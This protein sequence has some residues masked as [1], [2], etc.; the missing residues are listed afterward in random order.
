MRICKEGHLGQSK[1][2]GICGPEKENVGTFGKLV[3]TGG[4]I[5]P[6]GRDRLTVHELRSWHRARGNARGRK[7]AAV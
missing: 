4:M 5:H 7:S 3:D 2:C 1:K 6:N